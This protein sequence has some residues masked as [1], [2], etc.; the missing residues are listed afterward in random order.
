MLIYFGEKH[1]G[2]T[3]HLVNET[4]DGRSI[5]FQDTIPIYGTDAIL[6]LEFL[7]TAKTG[8]CVGNVLSK[9]IARD[10]GIPQKGKSTYFGRKEFEAI[11][12]INDPY[13]L[14]FGPMER[15]L[16]A[17]KELKIKVHG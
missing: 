1:T 2:F 15:R 12:T 7:K 13:E 16:F 17:F 10:K 5:P 3:Y 14:T 6:D 8:K 4:I 11:T 9:M